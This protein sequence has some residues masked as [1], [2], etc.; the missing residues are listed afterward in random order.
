M[1]K[2]EKET[3]KNMK[4]FVRAYEDMTVVTQKEIDKAL[5]LIEKQQK[6]I[7]KQQKEIEYY[8]N[9]NK[10]KGIMLNKTL[11][12][13]K[14]SCVSKDKIREKIKLTETLRRFLF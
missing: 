7:E 5:K 13:V 8:K 1:N 11:N 2:E 4:V 14:Q 3:I 12:G 10:N 6:L 9:Q